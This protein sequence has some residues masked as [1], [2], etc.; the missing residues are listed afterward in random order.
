M[1]ARETKDDYVQV[2]SRHLC[3]AEKLLALAPFCRAGE[4][5]PASVQ[6]QHY[7]GAMYLAG[8]AVECVLKAYLIVL[9]GK[10][11]FS[12]VLRELKKA[13]T[14]VEMAAHSLTSL[15][16]ASDLRET[17]G[18]KAGIA[19]CAKW[20]T[21]WR[22]APQVPGFG[23]PDARDFVESAKLLCQWINEERSKKEAIP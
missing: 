2:A 9:H 12:E 10:S 6:A 8:Y 18:S 4:C 23:A 15:L 17:P 19:I 7:V 21:A 3:D 22:Y 20:T 14:P 5:C 11:D 13:G 16:S 1:H